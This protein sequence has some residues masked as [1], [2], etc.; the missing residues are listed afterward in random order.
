M[1]TENLERPMDHATARIVTELAAALL[2]HL[3]E[4][5]SAELTR[6]IESLSINVDREVGEA[7]S[8]L[9]RLNVLFEGMTDALNSSQSSAL[10]LSS[11]LLSLSRTCEIL[12]TATERIEQLASAKPPVDSAQINEILH[13]VEVAISDWSG[14]LKS[15]GHAQT[16]ELSEFS[17]EVYELIGG[18]KSILSTMLGEILE[19]TLS[20]RTEDWLRAT[21][22]NARA[23]EAR[24]S[25]LEKISKIIL[26]MEGIILVVVL[27]ASS[28]MLYLRII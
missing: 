23:L 25:K 19:K 22:E 13:S 20:L 8:S 16:K 9:K 5:V 27:A 28:A 14:I 15:N 4:T 3:K 1:M 11:E 2:P 17:A 24:L 21:G 7:L 10:R 26:L 6:T 12:N 18:M